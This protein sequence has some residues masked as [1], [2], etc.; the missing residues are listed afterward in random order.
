MDLSDIHWHDSLILGVTMDCAKA[1]L[2]LHVEYPVSWE[3]NKFE[4]R[5]IVFADAYGYRE[6]E[7]PFSGCPTLLSASMSPVGRFHLVRLET[8][9][10]YREVGCSGVQVVPSARG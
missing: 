4:P 10:G 6:H 1:E 9:A 5:D 8:N 2:R 7:G 3:Q